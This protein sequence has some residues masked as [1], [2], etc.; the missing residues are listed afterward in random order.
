MKFGFYVPHWTGAFAGDDPR[1]RDVVDTAKAAEQT[2]LD[3][4]WVIGHHYVPFGQG[5]TWSLWDPWSLLAG[6]AAATERIELGPLVS[7][8]AYRN[9]ALLARTAASVDEISGGRLIVGIGGGYF[10]GEFDA[11]GIPTE[12]KVDRF[13]EAVQI[14]TGLLQ[15][16]EIDFVGEHYRASLLWDLP[17]V[18]PQG[19]PILIGASEPRMMQLAAKYADLWNAWL[20]FSTDS[21][22][23][24]GEKRRALDQACSAAGRDPATIGSIVSV[25]VGLLGERA[26][27]GPYDMVSIGG[28]EGEIVERLLQLQAAGVDHIQFCLAPATPRGVEALAAVTQQVA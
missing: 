23:D 28:A 11:V 6:L 3:S 22:G 7:C 24:F 1:W 27:F 2:G 4:L 16:G 12:R 17:R 14:I 25:A 9:P 20:P 13:E 8:T 19:P 10:D 21:V 5:V 18:R 15:D 26:V